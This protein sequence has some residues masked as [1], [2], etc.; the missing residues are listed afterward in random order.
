MRGVSIVKVSLQISDSK[1]GFIVWC[2][3]TGLA[4]GISTL[5][6]AVDGVPNTYFKPLKKRLIQD[7]FDSARIDQ[8]YNNPTVGFELKGVSQYFVHNEAKLNYDQFAEPKMIKKARNYMTK[9]KDE[10]NHAEKK[11][12]VDSEVITAI[13]LV[14]TKLGTYVGKHPIIPILSTMAVMTDKAPRETVWKALPKSRRYDRSTYD[15][16]A[17]SKSAWAYKELKAFLKYTKEHR[18]DP[19]SIVGSYAGALGIAQFMPSNVLAYGDDGDQ[20]GQIN[21]FQ[22]ADA[23]SSIAS[24]LKHYGWKPGIS[25][26][27]AAKVVYH[28]NH[29]KYYVNTVLKITDLLKTS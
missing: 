4:L 8:I 23:I 29:S 5:L 2:L 18:L 27:D 16:K 20:D 14:E 25:E 13:M 3:T 24:Y 26:K 1:F 12:G 19:M 15:K 7:G 9:H 11:F 21:L 28:Y 6:W 10:L 22:H 17:D